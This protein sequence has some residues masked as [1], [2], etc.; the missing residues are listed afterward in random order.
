VKFLSFATAI[1]ITQECPANGL[2][3]LGNLA[4]DF[5]S[6]KSANADIFA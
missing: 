1:G 2:G 6:G 5:H 4:A 3:I